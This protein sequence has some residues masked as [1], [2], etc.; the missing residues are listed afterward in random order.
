M[1]LVMPVSCFRFS[2]IKWQSSSRRF[3]SWSHPPDILFFS[4]T[5]YCF[6]SSI[7]LIPHTT[8]LSSNTMANAFY[9]SSS[10]HSYGDRLAVHLYL[11]PINLFPVKLLRSNQVIPMVQRLVEYVISICTKSVDINISNVQAGADRPHYHIAVGPHPTDPNRYIVAG[12]THQ[13]RLG[14]LGPAEALTETGPMSAHGLRGQVLLTPTSAHVQHISRPDP[15]DGYHGVVGQQWIDQFHHCTLSWFSIVLVLLISRS[16]SRS[17]WK[18]SST[19]CA[20]ACGWRPW[21]SSWYSLFSAPSPY[22]GCTTTRGRSTPPR[23]FGPG[24]SPLKRG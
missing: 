1:S 21:D 16:K 10:V 13:G 19:L 18:R 15:R 7:T 12:V 20:C 9:F 23:T 8:A 5:G 24:R 2:W 4:C 11:C 3:L 14:R 17:T 6:S 22:T